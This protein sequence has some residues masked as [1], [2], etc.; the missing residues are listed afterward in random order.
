MTR[1]R[2]YFETLAQ[3]LPK[4]GRKLIVDEKAKGILPLLQLDSA[5]KEPKP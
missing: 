4:V 3:V 2:I 5:G 1:K